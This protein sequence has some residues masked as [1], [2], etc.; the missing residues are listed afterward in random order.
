MNTIHYCERTIARMAVRALYLEVH[1]HPKPGLVS[2]KDAGA[3]SDMNGETLFRSLFTLRHYFYHISRAGLINDSFEELKQLAI[4]AEKR[5]LEKTQGINTHRG[6]IFALGIFCVSVRRLA[7]QKKQFT[8]EELQHQIFIDWSR[9]L[10]NHHENPESHGSLVRKRYQV[11]DARHM[12]MRGYDIIFRILP[13]FL[14]LFLKTKSLNAVCLFAYSKLLLHLDDTNVLY[15][16]GK[17]ALD[18]AQCQVKELMSIQCL[19]ARQKRG[20]ELH[21]LFSS[22]GIS[23]GGVADLIGVLLFLGQL[24]CEEFRNYSRSKDSFIDP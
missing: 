4:E 21:Q 16:R 3:H 5:M 7:H 24:F 12:A 9:H 6:A 15:R 2:F 14:S 22:A 1:A 11:I 10:E 17:N 20:G 8:P 19:Q 18:F 23:P 13:C